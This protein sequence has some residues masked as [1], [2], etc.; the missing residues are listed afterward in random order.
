MARYIWALTK[1]LNTAKKSGN[2]IM[3]LKLLIE[4]AEITARAVG[5]REIGYISLRKKN[6]LKYKKECLKWI[7]QNTYQFNLMKLWKRF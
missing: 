2:N 6:R 4:L 5:V 1:L 3:V 7:K